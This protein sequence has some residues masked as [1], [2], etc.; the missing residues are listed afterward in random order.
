MNTKTRYILASL[1]M[2]TATIAA[3]GTAMAAKAPSSVS[4]NFRSCSTGWKFAISSQ[5]EKNQF[6]L[7]EK[8][9]VVQNPPNAQTNMVQT[10]TIQYNTS[11]SSS[12]SGSLAAGWGPINA[13]VGYQANLTQTWT[14]S[15]SITISVPPGYQEYVAYG[16]LQN[17]WYGNYY[18]L[19]S[20]CSHSNDYMYVW[21]PPQKADRGVV[22][23]YSG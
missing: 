20:N 10:S 7:L 4:P 22:S 15:Q 2:A 8:G 23:S 6:T 21:S 9:T 17:E 13:A 3:T 16:A 14:T 19:Q 1:V 5:L 12:T 11:K 18:Y